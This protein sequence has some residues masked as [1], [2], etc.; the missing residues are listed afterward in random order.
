MPN[1]Q[2]F[3]PHGGREQSHCERRFL[4]WIFDGGVE[5][6]AARLRDEEI[7][8]EVIK[9]LTT[10]VSFGF[11]TWNTLLPVYNQFVVIGGTADKFAHQLRLFNFK[12]PENLS[13]EGKTLAE[14]ASARD[15]GDE[16]YE[17]FLDLT[18]EEDFNLYMCVSLSYEGVEEDTFDDND[19]LLKSALPVFQLPF[20]SCGSDVIGGN[21]NS[22]P[23]LY[24]HFPRFIGTIGRDWEAF[25]LEEAVHKC[26]GLPAKQFGLKERGLIKAGYYADLVIFDKD[27]IKERATTA[28]CTEKPDG[29]HMVFLNGQKVVEDNNYLGQKGYG[30]VLRNSE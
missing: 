10:A 13:F 17:V 6:A 29:I 22:N 7:R 1:T 2:Q 12:E 28:N 4:C 26:T 5:L 24:A 14:I 25:P 18:L 20:L 21:R 15:Q 19:S 8:K 3:S 9:Y 27:T 23:G 16:P 30:K 11:D